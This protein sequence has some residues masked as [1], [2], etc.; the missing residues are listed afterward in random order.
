MLK[1]WIFAVH[2]FEL[3]VLLKAQL[4]IHCQILPSWPKNMA[5]KW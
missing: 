1:S 4:Q 2:F 5:Q 3:Q